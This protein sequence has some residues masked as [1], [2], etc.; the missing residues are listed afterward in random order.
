MGFNYVKQ[1]S[2]F[3]IN[4][5]NFKQENYN[6]I[7]YTKEEGKNEKGPKVG[8]KRNKYKMLPPDLK[9]LAVSLAKRNDPKY[10]SNFYGVPLKSLKRWIKVGCERKKGGGRK[11]KDPLMEKNLYDWYCL[12]K[13]RDEIV[14]AKMVKDKAMELTNCNDFIASKGWLDKFKVR[15]NL[16]ISKE[17]A[18]DGHRKRENLDNIIRKRGR[19]TFNLHKHTGLFNTEEEP[20]SIRR[21]INK[22]VKKEDPFKRDNIN[23]ELNNIQFRSNSKTWNNLNTVIKEESESAPGYGETR[24]QKLGSIF[25]CSKPSSNFDRKMGEVNEMDNNKI[26]IPFSEDVYSPK[27]LFTSP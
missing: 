26:S 22:S 25:D 13:S 1:E 27:E 16:E 6:G 20:L 8:R 4:S 12:Q 18:R 14:T 2:P 7:N 10:S 21:S 15:Y 3:M 9:K 24:H 5:D 17:W 11:T 19:S 23:E